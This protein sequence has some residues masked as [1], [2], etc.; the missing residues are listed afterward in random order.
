MHEF[1]GLLSPDVAFLDALLGDALAQASPANWEE[2]DLVSGLWLASWE[3]DVAVHVLLG[4][5]HISNGL[6]FSDLLLLLLLL[7]SVHFWLI[8]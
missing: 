3:G 7:L 1:L 8:I 5:V 2:N 4:G 6:E